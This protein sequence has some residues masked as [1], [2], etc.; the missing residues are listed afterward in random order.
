MLNVQH[1]IKASC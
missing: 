1:P